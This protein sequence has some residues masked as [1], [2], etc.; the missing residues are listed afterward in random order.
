MNYRGHASIHRSSCLTYD[1]DTNSKKFNTI[2]IERGF[3]HKGAKAGRI[4]G[5]RDVHEGTLWLKIE[6][7]TDKIVIQSF[8]VP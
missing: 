4:Y 2:M 6:K 1:L 7:N 8:T 3:H 5:R